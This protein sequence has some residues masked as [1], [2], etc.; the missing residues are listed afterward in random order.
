MRGRGEYPGL[1]NRFSR[2]WLLGA[3]LGGLT[4]ALIRPG[5]S[6]AQDIRYFRIGTGETGG[7]LFIL[8]GVMALLHWDGH[9]LKASS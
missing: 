4:A 7:S 9:F 2:R 8:G 3:G 6:L 1:T 5:R